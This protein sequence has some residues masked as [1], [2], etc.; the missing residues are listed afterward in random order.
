[1]LS[2]EKERTCWVDKQLKCNVYEKY[3]IFNN[4]M[5]L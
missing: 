1:V 3:Q 5:H 4:L 2:G